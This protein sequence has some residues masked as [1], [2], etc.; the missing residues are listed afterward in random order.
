[1]TKFRQAVE[2][3]VHAH[4]AEFAEFEKVQALY[5]QDQTKYQDKFDEVGKPLVRVIEMTE[6]KLCGKMENG[7][8]G[9]FSATLADKFRA[10]V[11]A[12]FPL[13]DFVGVKVI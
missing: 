13:I 6:S 11:K 5:K 10:E 7:G 2:E 3:M 1:M 9:K 12:R 8:K 4:E